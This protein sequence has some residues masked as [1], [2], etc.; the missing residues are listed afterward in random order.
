MWDG[1]L[2]QPLWKSVWW[3][4]RKFDIVLLEDPAIPLIS[5]YP[6]D[7]PTRNKDSCSTMFLAALFI[8]ARSR[9]QPR[10]PS[11]EEWIQKI[12]NIYT[13]EYYSAIK[14]NEFVKFLDKWMDLENITL[15]EITQSQKNTH[16]MHSLRS[17]Y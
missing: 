7:V 16:D 17:G 14:N 5:I 9:K 3:F 11:I 12:W 15:T 4:F 1:N 2:V 6:E 8:I 10:C 13:M